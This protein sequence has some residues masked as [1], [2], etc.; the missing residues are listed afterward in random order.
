MKQ[1]HLYIFIYYC[2]IHHLCAKIKEP[3]D[4]KSFF[5]SVNDST[6]N[7]TECSH[8]VGFCRVENRSH[9]LSLGGR[10]LLKFCCFLSKEMHSHLIFTVN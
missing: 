8:I 10:Q 9:L 1:S 3:A 5:L 2:K 6:E 7:T 4:N